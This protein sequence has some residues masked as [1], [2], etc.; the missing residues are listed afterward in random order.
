MFLFRIEKGKILERIERILAYATAA[1]RRGMKFEFSRHAK[2]EMDRREI[3]ET[4]VETILQ[5]P[6]QIVKEYGGRKGYQSI[7]GSGTEKNYLVRVIVN[8]TVDPAKI[9][10]VYRTS[11]IEKYWRKP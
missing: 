4:V 7:I 10:T 3:S 2:E 1:T 8:D 11:K 5:N 9:I 6:E